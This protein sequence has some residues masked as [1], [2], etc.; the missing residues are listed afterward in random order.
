[1]R[2][3]TS[4][5]VVGC[6]ALIAG[7]AVQLPR[8]TTPLAGRGHLGSSS[9][10]RLLQPN[11]AL[12]M[13]EPAAPHFIHGVTPR[14]RRLSP[15]AAAGGVATAHRAGD[16]VVTRSGES[17]PRALLYRTGF[18][19]GEP[20][21]GVTKD[22]SIFFQ[23]LDGPPKVIRGTR[24]ANS[25]FK[26]EDVSP[27]LGGRQRHPE[28]LDPYLFVDQ[29][30]DRVFTLDFLFGCSELSFTDDLAKSWTTSPLQ[31]GE[32]DHQTLFA[33]PPPK[34]STAPVGYPDVVYVCSSQ[35]GATIYS[36]AAQCEKSLDGGVSFAPTGEP[37]YVTDQESE[38]DLGVQ[39]YCHGAIGHGFVGPDG[40]VYIPKGFCG[41][42]WLAISH[43][44]G[45]TWT[46]VQ[47]A[48]NGVP[49]SP[50]G[51]FEHEAAVTADTQGNVYYFWMSR[52]RL[53]YLAIS[54]DGG[55]T[56]SKPMM[57][58][59]PGVK[60]ATLPSLTIG[61][62]GKIAAV[63][64][65]STNSPG[66]PFPESKDCKPDP[67]KCFKALFFLNP[68]D[69]ARYKNVTWNGYMTISANALAKKPTFYSASIN[70]PSDPFVRGTCGPIRCKAVYDFID[71]V[72]DRQGRPW[73]SYVD[74]CI[75]TCVTKG[76][77]DVGDEGVVG[78]LVG[79]PSLR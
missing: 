34:S 46:R 68:P 67:A 50:T 56:W 62:D 51:V 76:P 47:V 16:R 44:E 73:A 74:A 13:E 38:N 6:A 63:Y 65:G 28:S 26:W 8:A 19:A 70:D 22:G 37:A 75:T 45:A 31:C 42:P 9:D 18:Q 48:K 21:I 52:D 2:V 14:R 3:R 35:A 36:V 27:S 43:D 29:R 32:Q 78:T 60:E 72:I 54:R 69:P 12:D 7:I 61:A 55:K 15:A 79:G 23:A 24:S 30:T 57:I 40:T 39:G 49:L 17:S 66:K 5:A 11:V 59:A 25:S 4:I 64:Y 77:N 53:P 58:G 41:Q 20:M 71:V 33:G 1:M 10:S